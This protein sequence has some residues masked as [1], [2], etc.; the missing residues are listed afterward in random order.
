M[1]VGGGGGVGSFVDCIGP[2]LIYFYNFVVIMRNLNK[3]LW[4]K[5]LV[6]YVKDNSE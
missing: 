2:V 6:I 3:C 1:K 4:K 5:V